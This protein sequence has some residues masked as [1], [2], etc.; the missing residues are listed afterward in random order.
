M[1]AALDRA[2]LELA[3]VRAGLRLGEV[4][5]PGPF[6]RDHPGQV[7]GLLLGRAVMM[8]RVDR[9][10]VQQQHQAEAHVG[11][12]PHLLHGGG[13]K[14]RHALAA[15]L[16]VEGQG[17][18]AAVDE[19]LVDAGEAGRRAHHA[20]LQL[21]ADLVAVAVERREAVAGE[22]GR[23]LEHGIDECRRSHARS[24][25]TR[26]RCRARPLRAARNA[27]RRAG[28]YKS[29]HSSGAALCRARSPS[30]TGR[31]RRPSRLVC[32]S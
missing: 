17:V 9:A 13:E 2:A 10:L 15:E 23:L 28:R 19:F 30:A 1:V 18:P 6:A 12:L 7:G 31:L 3:E 27:C 32:A 16:R 20:V 29:C 8:D 5:R 21:G 26:R 22:L 4:H 25:A 24:P 14:P 11:R